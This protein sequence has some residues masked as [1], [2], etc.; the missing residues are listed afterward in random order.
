MRMPSS[1]ALP[2]PTM[3]AVGVASPSAHG[4]AMI[5]TAM[6]V[7]IAIVQRP[8]SGP[9]TAQAAKVAAA[10]TSTTGTNHGRDPV[11]EPLHRHLGALRVLDQPHDLGQR[12]VLADGGGPQHE[13]CRCG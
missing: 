3:T 4:Q 11:G 7:V 12:G 2:V 5:S 10:R 6:V 8:S 1:A 9:N 13:R